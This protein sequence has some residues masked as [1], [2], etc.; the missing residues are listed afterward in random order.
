L[1]LDG[2]HGLLSPPQK[3]S[4]RRALDV[5]HPEWTRNFEQMH[6]AFDIGLGRRAYCVRLP[7]L[8]A[9]IGELPPVHYHQPLGS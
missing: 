7:V 8:A 5:A 1:I 3:K 2:S 9:K 6:R 4:P